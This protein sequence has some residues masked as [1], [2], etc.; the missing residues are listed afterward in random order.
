MERTIMKQM[1]KIVGQE[2]RGYCANRCCHRVGP[3][4]SF[5]KCSSCQFALY[6]SPSCQSASWNEHHRLCALL[7]YDDHSTRRGKIFLSG[8]GDRLPRRLATSE[9]SRLLPNLVELVARSQSGQIPPS[10]IGFEIDM[11]AF[12]TRIHAF[13]IKLFAR[14]DELSRRSHRFSAICADLLEDARNW[15][16]EYQATLIKVVHQDNTF[17]CIVPLQKAAFAARAMNDNPDVLDAVVGAGFTCQDRYGRPLVPRGGDDIKKIARCIRKE[18]EKHDSDDAVSMW[19][20]EF[21]GGVI[22]RF[23]N[24]AP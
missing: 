20:E 10:R 9:L 21:I 15:R 18:A 4:S 1:Y 8:P 12:P 3:R 24:S 14:R 17:V 5:R 7:A 13:D 11:S 2:E 16:G 23:L 6:C 19:D 22:E